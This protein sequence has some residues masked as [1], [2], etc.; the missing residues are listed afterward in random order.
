MHGHTHGHTHYTLY[1][2][3]AHVNWFL[4]G[5]LYSTEQY[6]WSFK[7]AN[8]K[9]R[10]Q[11]KKT[12]TKKPPRRDQQSRS[13]DST[14]WPGQN[15]KSLFIYMEGSQLAMFHTMRPWHRLMDSHALAAAGI[16]S[17][18]NLCKRSSDARWSILG[19]NAWVPREGLDEHDSFLFQHSSGEVIF[20]QCFTRHQAQWREIPHSWKKWVHDT[21]DT[22]W[23]P[24]TRDRC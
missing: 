6:S 22:V 21:S 13:A 7:S 2:H 5:K 19:W 15:K 18:L 1:W 11:R 17:F 4:H 9:L 20:G 3:P 23:G 16:S 12:T 24:A 10:A 8:L 14:L